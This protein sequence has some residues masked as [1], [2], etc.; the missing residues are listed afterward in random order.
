MNAVLAEIGALSPAV[1]IE[2]ALFGGGRIETRGIIRRMPQTGA[3]LRSALSTSWQA[4]VPRVADP[5]LVEFVVRVDP[6]AAWRVLDRE[7]IGTA[8]TFR[9]VHPRGESA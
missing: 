4:W 9:L 3:Q 6:R 8:T 2:L 5:E 7:T 1:P